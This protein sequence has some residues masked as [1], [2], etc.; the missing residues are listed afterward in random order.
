MQLLC[1]SALTVLVTLVTSASNVPAAENDLPQLDDGNLCLTRFVGSLLR[2]GNADEA[3]LNYPGFGLFYLPGAKTC[4]GHGSA[5]PFGKAPTLIRAY[6][7][8]QA[9]HGQAPVC[10][11]PFSPVSVIAYTATTGCRPIENA[12]APNACALYAYRGDE[13]TNPHSVMRESPNGITDTDFATFAR[14]HV[15]YNP[16]LY[17]EQ[18][19]F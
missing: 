6:W 9:Q 15:A 3:L 2:R 1:K 16:N 18:K 12:G 7:E 14:F 11:P 5:I 17:P 19:C 13:T 8:Y 10:P 4:E